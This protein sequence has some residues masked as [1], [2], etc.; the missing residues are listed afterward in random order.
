M[1]LNQFQSTKYH[2]SIPPAR[3]HEFSKQHFGINPYII[4][5]PKCGHDPWQ[6]VT[7]HIG[8]GWLP[9]CERYPPNQCWLRT[10][11][12]SSLQ[13]TSS[14][15]KLRYFHSWKK[16]SKKKIFA[17]LPLM[18]KSQ[19]HN[20]NILWCHQM[21]TFSTLLA[22]CAGN[23]QVT[24]EFLTQRPVMRSFYIS[25]IC[26]WINDWVNNHEASDL[27]CHR[28]HY[29]VILMIGPGASSSATALMTP[30]WCF[31]VLF[32]LPKRIFC[33]LK[34]GRWYVHG[35]GSAA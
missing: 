14:V 19:N 33:R 20:T 2:Y 16:S 32:K 23:S 17:Q 3:S 12:K 4:M 11:K 10:K 5:I 7:Y 21:E 9:G 6:P 34:F 13:R 8:K 25:L 31:T 18:S 29:D 22:L 15:T 24:G 28:A 1:N 35:D 30:T 27:R 26:A